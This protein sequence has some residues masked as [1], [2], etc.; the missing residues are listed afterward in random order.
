MSKALD[1]ALLIAALLLGW[2][3]LH[4]YA[5]ETAISSPWE[6]V[7]HLRAQFDRP[8]FWL[9]L[10]ESLK[11]FSYALVIAWAGGIGIGVWLGA[12]RF[13]GEI[14]EPLVVALYS[15]PKVTLY[16]LVLL[17]FGLGLS[18]K[19]A[20]GAI[21]GILPVALFAMNSVRNIRP[22]YVK[23]GRTLRLTP[24][25]A[26]TRVLIPAALP[27]IATGLR[28]GFSLT[29]LGTLIGEMFA[30]QRGLGFM[31]VNAINLADT[32]TMMAVTLLLFV[33]AAIANAILLWIDRTLHRR[34]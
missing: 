17:I 7:L 30:S 29:L 5:G 3:A 11:A 34:V 33:F 14:A 2:Q 22:V 1:I 6:T 12:N 9:H 8:R 10:E 23:A 21:H 24:L 20:F 32:K 13:A 18:S 4:G 31:I 27:E 15:L 16:P 26:A 19:V 25:D 28:L